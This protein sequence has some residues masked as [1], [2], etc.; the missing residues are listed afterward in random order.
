VRVNPKKMEINMSFISRTKQ[1]F[2]SLFISFLFA[3]SLFSQQ[4]LDGIAAIVDDDI[5][6]RSEVTQA[7]YIMAMQMKIDPVKNPTEFAKLKKSALENLINRNLLLI[8]AKKD[9]IKAD[10]HQVDAYLQQEMQKNIQQV[11]GEKKLEEYFGTTL[12]KIRRQYREEIEKNLII[13]AVQNQKLANVK[14][15]PREVEAF[16][17][18]HK[19]SIGQVKETVDISHIL[20]EAQ[21]GK[22]ARK[23][24]MDRI[25]M[26]RKKIM[27]GADFAE[28]AKEFSDDPGSAARGGDLGFMSRGDFVRPFEEAAFNLKPNEI[29]GIVETEYGFHIIQLLEKRGDKI[30]TRHILVALKPTKEDEIAAAN[31]IKKIYSELK[32]GADFAKMVEKYSQDES[33]NKQQGHLGTFEIDQLRQTAKEFVFALK[34][35]KVGGYSDPVK[36]KYGFHILKLNSREQP[37][38]LDLKKDWDKIQQMALAFKKQQEFKK[39]LQEIKEGIYIE[40]KPAMS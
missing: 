27:D 26:I 19:D 15:S 9:T 40:I 3:T 8:Q 12:S 21:P 23:K 30:H 4:L 10:E 33:T 28:M 6:L 35:V 31:K 2:L 24:A 22:D 38:E 34:G 14:V 11:G 16:F 25:T 1:I 36:T 29:S 13:S 20:I 32:N 37:R 7:A 17:K 18:T 5:I 39:Y